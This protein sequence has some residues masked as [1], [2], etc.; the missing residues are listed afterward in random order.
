MNP[1]I[2]NARRWD[3][4]LLVSLAALVILFL[5]F[6]GPN[7]LGDTPTYVQAVNVMNGAQPP[8]DF[9]PNRL[10]TT[11][12]PLEIVR[13]FGMLFGNSYT[14]WFL[15]NCVLYFASSIVFYRLLVKLFDSRP[16]AYLGTLF[17]AGSYGYLLFGLNYLM[18]IG[19]WSFYLFALHFL[20][21]YAQNKRPRDLYLAA[22]MVGIGGL[23]KEY[24]FLGG[25]AIGAYVIIEIFRSRGVRAKI[26]GR[27]VLCSGIAAVPTLLLY[28]YIYHRFGYTY[29]DWFG[30]NAVH[31]VYGSR[32]LEYIKALGSLMN[33]L[34]MLFIGG[35]IVLV[36]KWRE[37][38]AEMKIFLGAVL[39]SFLP[40]FA[41]P[42]ITQRILT[43]TVPFAVMIACFVFEKY[44]RRWYLFVPILALYVLATF[45]MDAFILK[46]V[47]LPF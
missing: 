35:A 43:I 9:I 23:F 11:F 40:V 15:L 19:G 31:Y 22:L 14:G 47:N 44:Q 5:I 28:A 3:V 34:G 30:A 21:G 46:A 29:L 36:R 45:C 16:A 12:G 20:Y 10:L 1:A 18:D 25:A 8:H 4:A 26:F 27:L 32:I 41:W 24:A 38:Q 42:A 39:I 17:L 6:L 33:L 13:I 37:M 2:S 7:I